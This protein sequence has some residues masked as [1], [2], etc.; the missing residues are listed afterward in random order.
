MKN[1]DSLIVDSCL[2]M[3][4]SIIE[5]MG[6]NIVYYSLS[7]DY[8]DDNVILT[9]C[10][11]FP[12][13]ALISDGESLYINIYVIQTGTSVKVDITNHEQIINSVD[14]IISTMYDE[15]ILIWIKI[16]KSMPSIIFNTSNPRP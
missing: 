2:N 12:N 5:K 10:E 4:L 16:Y 15:N 8:E 13:V 1:V 7:R 11:G 14:D 3:Y 9:I 6:S